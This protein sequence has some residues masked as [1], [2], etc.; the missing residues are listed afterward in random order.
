MPP[1]HVRL[2]RVVDP[3]EYKRLKRREVAGQARA[4]NFSCFNSRPFLRSDRACMWL[5]DAVR[6]N[7]DK[8]D[9]HLWAYCF[10]PTHVH[11]FVYPQ[12][13]P[14]SVG[15]FLESVKKS[16]ALRAKHWTQ[17]HA[18]HRLAVM[19]DARPDGRVVHRFWERGGGYDRNLFKARAIWSMIDYIHRNPVTDGL[20]RRTG[21]WRW[22][23]AGWYTDKAESVL[24]LNVSKRPPRPERR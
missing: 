5:A 14:P 1:N 11:L 7:L 12:A 2:V 6:V 21:D 19:A 20:C 4:L 13:D 17:M 18:P 15:L 10:M 22:S 23:S 9:C 3:I 16:V 24:P 8:H